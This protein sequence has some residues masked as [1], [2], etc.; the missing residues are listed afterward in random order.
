M[1]GNPITHFLVLGWDPMR[2]LQSQLHIT[3]LLYHE[4]K[5]FAWSMVILGQSHVSVASQV[6]SKYS[7][8]NPAESSLVVTPQRI[9]WYP[10]WYG[11]IN[12]IC[13]G[14]VTHLNL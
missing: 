1:D 12:P 2:P 11:G 3:P 6:L 14:A 9:G 5:L 13:Y 4:S 7:C 8:G 10:V